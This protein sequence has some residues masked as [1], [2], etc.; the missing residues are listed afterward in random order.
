MSGLP[1]RHANRSKIRSGNG[2]RFGM[3]FRG[4]WLHFGRLLGAKIHEKTMRKSYEI[5]EAILDGF[6]RLLASLW[7]KVGLNGG[8]AGAGGKP[9]TWPRTRLL[10]NLEHAVLPAGGRGRRILRRERPCRQPP[11]RILE[12]RIWSNKLST[13]FAGVRPR[14]LLY[15]VALRPQNLAY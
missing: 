2:V 9:R 6:W 10:Q 14:I 7:R 15:L 4:F 1:F 3:D 5:W 8:R 13:V 11:K 12:I